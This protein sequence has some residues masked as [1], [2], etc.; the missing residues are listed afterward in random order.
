MAFLKRPVYE[1]T[2]LL[3]KSK[4]PKEKNWNIYISMNK[5]T[6]EI[7]FSV[8]F[9]WRHHQGMK[10][11]HLNNFPL[12]PAKPGMEGAERLI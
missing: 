12:I 8:T 2:Y 6:S 11:P 5:L 9:L 3:D 10:C 4:W 1:K 7:F